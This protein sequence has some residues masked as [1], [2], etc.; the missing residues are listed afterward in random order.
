[1]STLIHYVAF[2]ST[3]PMSTRQKHHQPIKK[4]HIQLIYYYYFGNISTTTTSANTATAVLIVAGTT[5]FPW[6]NT[7]NSSIIIIVQRH[8]VTNSHTSVTLYQSYR[9]YSICVA[10]FFTSTIGESTA[11]HKGA[12]KVSKVEQKCRSRS[13]WCVA[14]HTSPVLRQLRTKKA[15]PSLL[16]WRCVRGAV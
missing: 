9:M 10:F 1:M 2:L 4:V 14:V 16:S 13:R 5:N 11:F 7:L 15:S 6:W 3:E 8:S 12:I